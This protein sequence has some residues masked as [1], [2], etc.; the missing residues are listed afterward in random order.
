MFN[1]AAAADDC[2]RTKASPANGVVP[3]MKFTAAS[4]FV[5]FLDWAAALRL[6]AGEP[7]FFHLQVL[8]SKLLQAVEVVGGDLL[9]ALGE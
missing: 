4:V 6:V 2:A 9:F 3:H 1:G 8:V 7:V 5:R